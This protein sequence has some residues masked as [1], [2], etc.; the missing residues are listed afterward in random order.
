M[1]TFTI[2]AELLLVGL[3]A[4][5]HHEKNK[6]HKKVLIIKRMRYEEESK[7][8]HKRDQAMLDYHDH[9]LLIISQEFLSA[10]KD[11]GQDIASKS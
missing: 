1:S 2:I 5:E 3:R 6:I 4:W 11:G 8:T 10:S 9:E 7:P